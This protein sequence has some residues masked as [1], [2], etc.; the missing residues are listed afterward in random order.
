MP[1]LWL[2]WYRLFR[3]FRWVSPVSRVSWVLRCTRGVLQSDISRLGT[4]SGFS[5]SFHHA[6]RWFQRR[7]VQPRQLF[8]R[9]SNVSATNRL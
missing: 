9:C 4:A 2:C 5:G 6:G 8:F 1:Y 7:T 3:L